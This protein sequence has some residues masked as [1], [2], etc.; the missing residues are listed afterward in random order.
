MDAI[1]NFKPADYHRQASDKLA[2]CMKKR[3]I[4]RY[5]DKMKCIKFKV[6]DIAD[7]E[8]LD[9]IICGLKPI[10]GHEVHKEVYVLSGRISQLSNLFSRGGT[11]RK[12]SD[13]PDC[14]LIELDNMGTH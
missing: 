10:I 8:T 2:T 5:I 9:H 3:P 12:W 4:T 13:P 11:C 6:H 7:D 1:D 14:A